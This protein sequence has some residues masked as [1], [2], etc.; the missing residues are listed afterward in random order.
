MYH[1]GPK[2]Y[3]F[4]TRSQRA[5]ELGTTNKIHYTR[6]SDESRIPCPL[7]GERGCCK[8]V[9]SIGLLIPCTDGRISGY[10]A[11]NTEHLRYEI[12][13][14]LHIPAGLR[15]PI[16]AAHTKAV[17]FATSYYDVYPGEIDPEY[18]GDD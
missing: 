18:E 2:V 17:A 1:V 6:I 16:P 12:K 14:Y 13:S 7:T 9:E 10:R 8:I 11:N 3:P 5:K 15:P 4:K